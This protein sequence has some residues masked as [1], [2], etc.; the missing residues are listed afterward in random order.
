MTQSTFLQSPLPLY[1]SVGAETLSPLGTATV[2]TP[3][4]GAVAA[5]VTILSGDVCFSEDGST[6]TDASAALPSSAIFG[7]TMSKVKFIQNAGAAEISVE[8]L[9]DHYVPIRVV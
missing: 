4:A 6:P 3:P 7:A 9:T 5:L 8:F 1:Q 2:L